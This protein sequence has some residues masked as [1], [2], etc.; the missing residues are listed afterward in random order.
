MKDD[1]SSHAYWKATIALLTKILIIWFVV[2]FG[3]GILVNE[4]FDDDDHHDNYYPAWGYG[5]GGYY[6][7]PYRPVY[8]GGFHPAY[9]YNRPPN[10]Q[11]G[12][13]NNNVIINTGGNDYWNRFDNSKK[14]NYR[15]K[16]QS[17]I[18]A[19]RPNRPEL[20]Q[21][22]NAHPAARPY[23]IGSPTARWAG[24]CTSVG[25]TGA[26]TRARRTPP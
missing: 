15:N 18:S 12:F 1:D 5:G 21:R 24:C 14:N 7:P 26:T 10:Y 17:P 20:Q 19:A 13:N 23:R 2:S 22:A 11:H 16:A 8:G 4:M 3:A 6:P 25:S 9:G